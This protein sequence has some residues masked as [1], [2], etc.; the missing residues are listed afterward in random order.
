MSLEPLSV[1]EENFGKLNLE[2]MDYQ[3]NKL[4]EDL[5]SQMSEFPK[6]PDEEEE[7]VQLEENLDY[8]ENDCVP[9][10]SDP[11]NSVLNNSDKA[12]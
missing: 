10:V 9:E 11:L 7:R 5:W 8:Q 12:R 3:E 2:F 4:D 1:D 6:F